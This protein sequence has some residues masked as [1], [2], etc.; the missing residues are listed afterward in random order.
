[1]SNPVEAFVHDH[2]KVSASAMESLKSFAEQ[3]KI[4]LFGLRLSKQNGLNDSWFNKMF[5]ALNDMLSYKTAMLCSSEST[6]FI[7]QYQEQIK[8][9]NPNIYRT[10]LMIHEQITSII[11]NTME[12]A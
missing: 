5:E 9:L 1:M 12:T 4:A 3:Y 11:D 7:D 6:A 10:N 2:Y 8:A